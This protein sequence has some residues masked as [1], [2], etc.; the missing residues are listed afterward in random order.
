MDPSRSGL[1]DS[2]GFVF[3]QDPARKEYGETR[4]TVAAVN[5]TWRPSSIEGSQSV[6]IIVSWKWIALDGSKMAGGV[7]TRLSTYSLP[8]SAL[9]VTAAAG[10][11]SYAEAVLT[12]RVDTSVAVREG[13]TL[14]N[15]W[16]QVDLLHQSLPVFEKVAWVLAR[17]PALDAISDWQVVS[18][19]VGC[20]AVLCLDLER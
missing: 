14:S 8:T 2:D 11:C 16:E 9:T 1:P 19:D 18:L 12:A 7:D 20:S 13:L 4:L 15:E 6:K 10:A 5:P 3:S 17:V